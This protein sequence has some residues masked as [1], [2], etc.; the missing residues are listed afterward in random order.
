MKRSLSIG[1]RIASGVLV[2]LALVILGWV[3]SAYLRSDLR[4]SVV[5]SGL[6]LC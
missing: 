1:R 6:G 2:V 4:Q 5:F 3:T